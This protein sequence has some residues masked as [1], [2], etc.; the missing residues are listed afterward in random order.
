MTELRYGIIG[1]GDVVERKSGPSIQA[2]ERSR[3]V[4]VMRRD[5]AKARTYAERCG[6]PVWTDDAQAVIT[7]D[8]LLTH[9]AVLACI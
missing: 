5:A 7:H 6:A 3:I 8:N 2:A 9:W 1:C 4:A